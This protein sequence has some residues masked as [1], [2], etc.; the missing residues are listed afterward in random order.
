MPG[1]KVQITRF[2]DAGQP[3][4]V[5]CQFVDAHN[6]TWTFI[7]K[8]PIVT[9]VD[10]WSDSPYPQPGVIDCEV[11]KRFKD[12]VGEIV[13]V[14]TEKPWHVESIDG[15]TQFEIRPELLIEC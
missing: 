11:V 7:E 10:L 9:T 1:I 12:A 4:F 6:Q 5:E 2:V 8:L 15:E 14:T 13:A 3:G